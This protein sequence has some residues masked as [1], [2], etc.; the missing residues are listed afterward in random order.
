PRLDGRGEGAAPA[1]LP[2]RGAAVAHFSS[3]ARTVLV[4]D[5]CAEVRA[6]VGE[7]LAAAAQ[8]VIEAADGRRALE[9]VRAVELDLAILDVSMPGTDGWET[10]GRVRASSQVPILF[11]TARVEDVVRRRAE[12]FGAAG[13]MTKPF[14]RRDLLDAVGWMWDAWD[15]RADDAPIRVA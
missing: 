10:A 2:G 15:A 13:F 8:D 3:H 12:L 14:A 6:L 9:L 4:V 7:I 11:L 5:D 1:T